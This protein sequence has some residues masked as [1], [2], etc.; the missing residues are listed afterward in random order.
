MGDVVIVVRQGTQTHDGGVRGG[1][2]A[3]V[4]CRTQV[5]PVS[6]VTL[7]R[8]LAAGDVALSAV[9]Q[10]PAA[11]GRLERAAGDTVALRRVAV[12]HVGDDTEGDGASTA[13]V[14]LDVAGAHVAQQHD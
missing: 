8:C 6:G 11:P 9:R 12:V 4:R 13:S 7:I 2:V 14:D 1:H 5:V 3:L 10:L